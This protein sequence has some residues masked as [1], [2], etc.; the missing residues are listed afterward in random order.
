MQMRQL[1]QHSNIVD[2]GQLCVGKVTSYPA[3][4]PAPA[5]AP[6]PG[7]RTAACRLAAGVGA[8]VTMIPHRASG[9]KALEYDWWTAKKSRDARIETLGDEHELT[10]HS[11]NSGGGPA[12]PFTLTNMA[13]LAFT[14]PSNRIAYLRLVRI[15][16]VWPRRANY[17]Q[18]CMLEGAETLV[19]MFV[20][21]LSIAHAIVADLVYAFK[22][23]FRLE[24]FQMSF[25]RSRLLV[26]CLILV[27]KM[28]LD[29][30]DDLTFH[31]LYCTI[32]S[33][34]DRVLLLDKLRYLCL[35]P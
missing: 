27:A 32:Y 14:R 22:F 12:H 26:I 7:F 2:I 16:R 3:P 21:D 29:S 9:P 1:G 25:L 33:S 23:K 15:E 5:P 35:L 31:A 18:C 20:E 6:D 24:V 11:V 34:K 28:L 19:P 30:F 8:L 13:N 10:L 17:E 4:A